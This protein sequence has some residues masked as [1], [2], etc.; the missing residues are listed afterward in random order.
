MEGL[1]SSSGE[2]ALLSSGS[3][4]PSLA[5]IA[6]MS[7]CGAWAEGAWAP[8]AEVPGSR[9]Q[10]QQLW[11]LGLAAPRHVGSSRARDGTGVSRAGR[12]ILYH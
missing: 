6:W 12:R 8:V 7:C 5:I 3:A 2:R 10:T 1:F 9:A 4:W 11:L